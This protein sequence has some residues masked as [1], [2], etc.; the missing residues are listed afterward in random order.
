MH[1]NTFPQAVL[2]R[3]A[4]RRGGLYAF[5]TIDPRK[6]ALVVV[7]MQNAFC[8][9]GAA[10][11]VALAKEIVPNI[12]LLAREMRAVSGTVAWVQTALQRRDD[13]PVF[14]NM[15]LLPEY[16]DRYV[17]DLKPGGEGYKLWPKLEADT[18]DLYVTKNRFSAF[19][20]SA[21]RLPEILRA[22]GIDTVLIVG[23]L[24]NVCCESSARDAAM[25]D[26]RTIMIGDANACRSDEEHIASLTTF[27][28]VF[29][30]VRSTEQVVSLLR[31]SSAADLRAA[32]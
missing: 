25:S 29:G 17:R 19:L 13:W 6:T 15:L 2:D 27:F 28:Q 16:A 9:A 1:P 32:G 4:L 23:T 7:D 30:D 14:L 31:N 12:N 21:S 22:R 18:S 24:T 8:A 26:F 11:E 20:P 5:E 3:I 10:G